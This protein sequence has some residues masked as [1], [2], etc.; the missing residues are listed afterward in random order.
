MTYLRLLSSDSL[1]AAEFGRPY[2]ETA[3]KAL[4]DMKGQYILAASKVFASNDTRLIEWFT[5]EV[6]RIDILLSHF[7]QQRIKTT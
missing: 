7:V 4:T 2:A 5:S 3:S 6:N 1:F